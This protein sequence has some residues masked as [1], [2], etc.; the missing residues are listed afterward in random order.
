M[1]Y[2]TMPKNMYPRFY[3]KAVAGSYTLMH[4][5][6]HS[7]LGSYTTEE[8]LAKEIKDW[9]SLTDAKELWEVL[10]DEGVRVT[11]SNSYSNVSSKDD[12][13]DWFITAWSAYTD[14][15]YNEHPEL[16]VTE[17]NLPYEIINEIRRERFI[18]QD[19][20]SK[21][22]EAEKREAEKAYQ[23][24]VRENSRKTQREEVP[25]G[26]IG[27][28][29]SIEKA[30]NKA[31]KHRKKLEIKTKSNKVIKIVDSDDLFA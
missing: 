5:L 3:I 26:K 6:T 18:E 19:K 10:L 25:E 14:K 22:M 28:R 7:Y 4:R 9:N 12:N 15:F 27:N 16:L 13:E 23:L 11:G 29:L 20:I 8:E 2:I 1:A 21:Q 24:S 31:K 30:R 17:E